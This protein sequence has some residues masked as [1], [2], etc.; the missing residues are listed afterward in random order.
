MEVVHERCCGLD[1]HKETVVACVVVPGAGKQPHKE[2]RTFNTMTADLLEL[3][4]W[5]MGKG[6]THVALES[7]GVYWKAPWNILESSFT[8]LLVNAQHIKQVPGR[9][10][11]VRDCEWI[12]DLLRHGLLRPA[13]ARV[14]RADPLSDY[15]DSGTC[16]RAQPHSED[17]GRRWDQVG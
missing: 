15:A 10:T 4:D 5:L 14:A 8:L 9:K 12:A 7:T 6:V 13:P 17:P 16:G 1:V 3:A 11:D 2:I